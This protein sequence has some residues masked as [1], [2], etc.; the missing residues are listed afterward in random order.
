VIARERGNLGIAVCL[1]WWVAFSLCALPDVVE[2]AGQRYA[3][4]ITGAT[5]GQEY[6]AKFEGWRNAFTKILRDAYGYPADHVWVLAEEVPESERATRTNVRAVFAELRKRATEGDLTVVL[7]IGHGSSEGGEAKFNLV[8]PDL[9][10]SDWAGLVKPIQGRVAFIN[11][12][13]GS[14]PFVPA[15]AGRDR[16]V[17]AANDSAEQQFETVFPE[18]FIKAFEEDAG[19]ADKNGKVSLFEAFTYASAMVKDWFEGRGR[20][21][22]E[23]AIL[24][25]T[26]GAGRSVDAAG[27]DGQLAQITY[28]EPEVPPSLT[29]NVELSNLLRRRA[30]LE[31]RIDLL[32]A[33]K[34]TTPVDRYEEELERLLIEVAR[35]DRQLRSKT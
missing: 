5:G 2:A 27:R 1:V 13:S 4:V 19:D 29:G 30:E 23:R 16:V 34:A 21:A 9:T 31:N 7:L 24:D 26:G 8:G 20:L 12:S 10:V 28:V 14:F 22:T 18:F 35:L 11:A 15:I 6:A 25:D 33:N 32:K 3:V 17:L